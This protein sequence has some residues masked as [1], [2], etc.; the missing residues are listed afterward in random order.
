M[1][2]RPVASL[3]AARS[4]A[5]PTCY[6]TSTTPQRHNA[7]STHSATAPQPEPRRHSDT[8]DGPF[9]SQDDI[10]KSIFEALFSPCQDNMSDDEQVLNTL[11]LALQHPCYQQPQQSPPP[12]PPQ[13]SPQQTQQPPHP[14]S[15]RLLREPQPLRS[16][17]GCLMSDK[18][19]TLLDRSSKAFRDHFCSDCRLLGVYI[20]N[21]R[22]L[23]VTNPETCRFMK[24]NSSA[25]GVYNID[26][27]T[28]KSYRVVN[29][30]KCCRT[31]PVIVFKDEAPFPPPEGTLS[32]STY[33]SLAA[34]T[35]FTVAVTL[36]TDAS[37]L[38]PSPTPPTSPP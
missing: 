11:I 30:T 8:P 18:K 25:R 29:Q 10:E 33:T 4:P 32:P 24:K 23:V 35:H 13:K 12:P 31:S 36:K 16:C 9:V 22:I 17:W 1:K 37:L 21:T 20:P 15:L 2:R 5:T 38:L 6:S 3:P 27:V 7:T 19:E 28:H 26:P 14:S 34:T